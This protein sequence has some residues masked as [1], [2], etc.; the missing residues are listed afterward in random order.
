MRSAHPDREAGFTLV[1]MLVALATF[2]VLA[3]AGYRVLDTVLVT[4]ERVTDD[5]RRWRAVARAVAW[6]E[7]DLEAAAARPV[8]NA[9]AGIVAPVVGVEGLT[10]P[11]QAAI[12]LTRGGGLDASGFAAPPSRIGYRVRDGALE[13]L[14]WH[15]LDQATQGE[16]A[17]AVVLSGVSRLGL[18]YRDAVGTWRSSWPPTTA[19]SEAGAASSHVARAGLVD[20]TLPTGI[21]VTTELA[22]GERIQRLV[23]LHSGP[24]S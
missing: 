10:Q 4:R 20:T 6:M 11:A 8:R 9:A 22:G 13:R 7:R 17:V 15:A 12:T 18:R 19:P 23:P 14:A 24:R 3:V 16:P 5:Y 21:D 2:G 1:E